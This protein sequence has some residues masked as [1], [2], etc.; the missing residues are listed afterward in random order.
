MWILI[1]WIVWGIVAFLALSFAWGCRSYT[2]SGRGFQWATGVVTFFWWLIAV[3]F[4][5]FGWNKLHILW[6]APISYFA[7]QILAIGGVPILSPITL[8]AT[9]MFLGLILIGID[10]PEGLGTLFHGVSANKIELIRNLVK[11]RIQNDPIASMLGDI[12]SLSETELM[13]LP[14]ATLVTIV[15]TYWQLKNQ[16]LSDEE[17]LEAIERH[18]AS[19]LD[20]GKLP[21]QLTLSNYIKYRIGLEHSHGIPISDDFIEEAIKQATK[22]FT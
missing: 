2:K 4:L 17:I 5:I 12:D 9:R 7:A 19:F 6:I 3:L 1:G 10:K 14:E 18:R 13:G 21:S 8:F 22:A 16:G 20:S 11:N 15:E